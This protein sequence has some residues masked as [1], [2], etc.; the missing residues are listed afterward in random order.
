[1]WRRRRRAAL[2]TVLLEEEAGGGGGG[3][4]PSEGLRRLVGYGFGDSDPTLRA[5]INATARMLQPATALALA[6]DERFVAPW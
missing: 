4:G 1:M 3:G 5:S 6:A 2:Q